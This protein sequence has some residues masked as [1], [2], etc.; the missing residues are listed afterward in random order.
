M[1]FFEQLYQGN[2]PFNSLGG[3]FTANL[4]ERELIPKG[5]VLKN[6]IISLKGDLAATTTV[7]VETFLDVLLPLVVKKG[8]DTIMQLRGRDLFAL[9]FFMES[10]AGR[11]IEGGAGEDD[12]VEGITI[13]MN[14][15]IEADQ[16]YSWG[17]T[18]AAVGNISGEQLGIEAEWNDE[19]GA[20]ENISAVEQPLTTAGATGPTSLNVIIPQ[21]G[22]LIGLMVFNTTVPTATAD[23]HSLTEIKFLQDGELKD[24]F[25]MSQGKGLHGGALANLGAVGRDIINNY[26]FFDFR[27]S[28]YDAK[29]KRISLD[30]EV[31][32]ASEAVRLIP[33]IKRK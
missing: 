27:E 5:K 31:G 33:I 13:P 3:A 17:A 26:S 4:S 2:S 19:P 16:N 14:L 30:I 1:K 6:L 12:K 20:L 25:H 24:V 10:K 11:C 15:V 32:V 23:T 8:Q 7:A 29:A 22:D 9:S 21:I 28:P 18:R